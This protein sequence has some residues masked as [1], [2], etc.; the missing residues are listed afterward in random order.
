MKLGTLAV[1]G[2][3][4]IGGSL[5]AKLKEQ[6]CVDKV[7]GFGRSRATLDVAQK[8]GLIDEAALDYTAIATA[9]VIVLCVPV[10]FTEGVL[11]G[12]APYLKLS[13]IVTDA[14]STKQDVVAAARAALGGKIAQFVPAHPIA[15][16][17]VHGPAPL[18]KIYM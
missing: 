18:T 9:D 12:I 16:N 5:A 10:A 11:R 7:I 2:V 17:A 6:G 13:A 4:L 1:I 15:G 14:G 8:L 3:G